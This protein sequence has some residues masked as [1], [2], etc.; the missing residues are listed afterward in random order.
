MKTY[1]RLTL[2]ATLLALLTAGCASASPTTAPAPTAKPLA[3]TNSGQSTDTG[4]PETT[5]ARATPTPGYTPPVLTA[6][7]DLGRTGRPI[8]VDIESY[9]LVVDGLVERPLSLSYDE[10]LSHPAVTQVPR[11]ECPGLFVNYAEWTGP[12]V[13]TLLQVAGVKPE[14]T[15]VEF[16]DGS[17]RP[18]RRTLTLEQALRD[19]TYLAYKVNGETLPVEHGYP[20]RLVVGSEQGSY[21]VK[22]LFRIEVK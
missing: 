22:W 18:Y 21:W 4:V 11:L 3:A 10:L 19:D 1:M 2:F 12:M 17:E 6:I 16:S 8:D 13:R 15:T 14:A 7:G 5:P 9:R 20:V